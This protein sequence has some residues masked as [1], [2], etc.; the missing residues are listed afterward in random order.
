MEDIVAKKYTSL[1]DIGC[2]NGRLVA[3]LPPEID[4]YLGI[5]ASPEMVHHAQQQHPH[6]TFAV[7]DMRSLESIPLEKSYDA[8]VLLA[9]FHHLESRTERIQVLRQLHRWI[10]R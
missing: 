6:H 3:S 10:A 9:S 1:L 8:I 4:D 7:G 5:D 2:G